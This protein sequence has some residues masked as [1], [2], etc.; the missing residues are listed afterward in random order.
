MD[1]RYLGLGDAVVSQSSHVLKDVKF[2]FESDPPVFGVV[3][4][5][6]PL[7][8]G[9]FCLFRMLGARML[10]VVLTLCLGLVRLSMF[11]GST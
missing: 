8:V 7:E 3:T 6:I 2:D 1:F 11:C 10:V 4:P 5:S 9:S